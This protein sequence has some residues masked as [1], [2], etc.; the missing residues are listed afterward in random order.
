MVVPEE[1]PRNDLDKNIL[2]PSVA[3]IVEIRP[4]INNVANMTL[5]SNTTHM[6]VASSSMAVANSNTTLEGQEEAKQ[7][8]E[9]GMQ[10]MQDSISIP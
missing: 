5:N 8:Q 3:P 1:S 4:S 10:Q 7:G 6:V 2:N 9:K